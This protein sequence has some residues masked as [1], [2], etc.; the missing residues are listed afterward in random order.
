MITDIIEKYL[1]QCKI[2]YLLTID[3]LSP[4]MF[5]L[6][7][8]QFIGYIQC[9]SDDY[10]QYYLEFF[11]NGNNS[12]EQIYVSIIDFNIDDYSESDMIDEIDLLFEKLII[13]QKS[14]NKIRKLVDNIKSLGFEIFNS[15]TP[16]ERLI[17][18]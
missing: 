18:L 4:N 5:E 1:K 17:N 14:I 11:I 6:F 7:V 9:E 13:C 8:G 10:G 12:M 16:I 3:P 2:K 15:D